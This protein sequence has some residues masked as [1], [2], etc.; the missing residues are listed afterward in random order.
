VLTDD[1]ETPSSVQQWREMIRDSRSLSSSARSVGQALATRMDWKTFQCWPGKETIARDSG[2]SKS[3]VKRGLRELRKAGYL[4]I[5]YRRGSDGLNLTNVYT[6][7][8]PPWKDVARVEST[9][10]ND[11]F[12]TPAF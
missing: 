12:S 11:P 7:R 3:S 4:W 2:L 10:A 6:A 5:T 9:L 1:V 8:R